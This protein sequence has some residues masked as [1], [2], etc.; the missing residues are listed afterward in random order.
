M[1][2]SSDSWLCLIIYRESTN[3]P[4]TKQSSKTW[5]IRGSRTSMNPKNGPVLCCSSLRFDWTAAILSVSF[6]WNLVLG[7]A[8]RGYMAIENTES[9]NNVWTLSLCAVCHTVMLKT[10]RGTFPQYYC[11]SLSASLRSKSLA[12]LYLNVSFMAPP[13]SVLHFSLSF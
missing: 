13:S 3:D 6:G 5:Q 1:S 4:F 7:C 2:W 8:E 9:F 10:H 12:G 11:V